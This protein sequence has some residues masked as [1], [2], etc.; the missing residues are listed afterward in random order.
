MSASV[1]RAFQL[2]PIQRIHFVGIGGSGMSGI[3][4]VLARR[5]Y[6]VS[7]SDAS[8][9]GTTDRLRTLGVRVMHGHDAAH[10]R[11]ADVVVISTAVG[12][13]NVERVA[14]EALHI[15]IVHRADMLAALMRPCLSVAVAGAHGKTTTTAMLTFALQEAGLD[16]TAVIGGTVPAFGGNARVGDGDVLVVEADE[17]DASFLRLLPSI[18]IITNI[19]DDHLD[20]YGTLAGVVDAFAAFAARVPFYGVVIGC[21]DDPR[22]AE[23]LT[24]HAGRRV[25]YGTT[26]ASHL[27]LTSVSVGPLASTATVCQRDAQG[28]VRELGQLALCVPGDHNLLNALA[29]I[30]VGLELGVPFR[31]L[32]DALGRFRAADRR[33]D[34]RGEARGVL[35]VDDYAHHPTEVAAV[36]RAAA[37]LQRRLVVAFQPHRYTRTAALGPAFGEAFTG[38]AAVFLTDIYAAGEAPLPGVTLE[39]FAAQVSDAVGAHR[40]HVAPTLDALVAALADFVRPGDVVLSVGAGSI[41]SVADALLERLTASNETLEVTS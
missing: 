4:E 35:V 18:A 30:A 29:A 27:H 15:P 1:S 40:V 5:G 33:F 20:Q 2:G 32:A 34:V 7:G 31:T 17:S 24:N 19:D 38:A 12:P 11:D 13:T 14:A 36:L 22:V 26:A 3:A 39:T 21:A 37:P 9:S 8:A 41:A 28:T 16:P 25:T 6:G 23:V 10:V